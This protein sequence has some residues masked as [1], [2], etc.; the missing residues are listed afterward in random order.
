MSAGNIVLSTNARMKDRCV[1]V[2]SCI[3]FQLSKFSGILG[4]LNKAHTENGLAS[5]HIAFSVIVYRFLG[6]IV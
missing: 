4:P 2:F 1:N 6:P 5:T 3:I